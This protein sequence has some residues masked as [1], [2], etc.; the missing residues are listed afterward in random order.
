M[1]KIAQAV[2]MAE[3]NGFVAGLIDMGVIKV[4]SE[5]EAAVIADVIEEHLPEEY[6][7]ND[8]MAIASDVVEALEGDEGAEP[9][10]EGDEEGMVVQASDYDEVDETALMAAY[11]ELSMAKHAGDISDEEFEKEAKILDSFFRSGTQNA[12]RVGK[13]LASAKAA[14]GKAVK[15]TKAGL[16]KVTGYLKAGLK[17]SG[18]KDNAKLLNA[19]NSK[20]NFK[21]SMAAKNV[22]SDLR[23]AIARTGVAYGGATAAT[24]G[25]AY[26]GKKLYDKYKK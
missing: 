20:R 3:V 5:E 11:G 23:K 10:A 7:M 6:D 24:A 2:R 18:I 13:A 4:A 17:G 19:L 14:P 9:E 26:G 25:A 8:A 1:E 12:R 16:G 21:G 15:A 22:S